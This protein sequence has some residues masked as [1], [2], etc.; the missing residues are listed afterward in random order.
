M[1]QLNYQNPPVPTGV[2]DSEVIS[3]DP[4]TGQ[5]VRHEFI[6]ASE[7]VSGQGPDTV[8]QDIL[9]QCLTELKKIRILLEVDVVPGLPEDDIDEDLASEGQ[10]EQITEGIEE[11]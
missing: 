9:L 1:A 3:I 10:E 7:S 6:I 8:L 5:E 11:E 4:V 2:L